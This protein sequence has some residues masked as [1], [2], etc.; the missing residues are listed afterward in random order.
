MTKLD[1]ETLDK[2]YKNF[3]DTLEYFII[4]K[5]NKGYEYKVDFYST[6][7]DE[8]GEDDEGR[9]VYRKTSTLELSFYTCGIGFNFDFDKKYR[10]IKGEVWEH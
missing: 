4:T 5:Q 9:S 6:Y 2:I 3:G 7:E 10:F 8:D 1:L